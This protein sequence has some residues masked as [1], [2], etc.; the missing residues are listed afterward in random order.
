MPVPLTH[1]G[2]YITE[3]PSGTRTITGVATSITAFVGTALRGP[4]DEPVTIFTY[5]DFVRVFG[6]LSTSSGLGY[7]VRDM[8]LNGGGE[9]VIVRIAPG[10]GAARVVAAGL[11]PADGL[12]LVA[13]GPGSWGNALSIIVEHPDGVDEVAA[14]QGVE[15]DDL[16]Q[17]TVTDGLTE[18]IYLNV[19]VVEGPRRIDRVLATSALIAVEGALP[20]TRPAASP[21][22]APY[23]VSA[24]GQGTDGTLPLDIT[25]EHY[26]GDGLVADKGGVYA[27]L[28]ADLFNLLCLPPPAPEL[29][30][31]AD[32]W[33]KALKFC[34][35]QRAFLIVDVPGALG[36]DGAKTWATG[37][38]LT[39]VNARNG[40]AYYPRLRA[41]DPL[42][43]GTIQDYVPCGAVAGLMART[44]AT[45]G[46]WKAPAGIDSAV[47]AV[48]GLSR[49]L[50]D[51]ENGVLNPVAVNCLRTFRGFGT[52]IWGA[53][54][55]RG[56]D[57]L[58]DEYKYVPVR[59]LALS[60]EETLY[61]NTQWVVFE[62]ND[63]PLW[64]QIRTSIGAFMQDLFRQG[65]FQGTTPRDAFFVRCDAET[66]TQYDI[67]RGIVNILV[68]FAPLKP[69][70]FVVISLQQKTATP[71]A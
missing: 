69:A 3:I 17:L 68:G 32:T 5:T 50:T 10:A 38:G 42:R 45:R 60:L 2:V 22:G 65:A 6:G 41:P 31:P 23:T 13:S 61:R 7:A 9:A 29:D 44:D 34:A 20:G 46:V 40:A 59:R 48:N 11:T 67:D 35:E 21:V 18:E 66:T 56:A 64:A 58:G 55:L 1:P 43:G 26:A 47:T 57:L 4:V 39:G 49:T 15:P 71:A 53:R 14:A 12:T 24:A 36:V 51:G 63:E 37:V 30:L 28:K 52:V 8:Y 62:P 27:L 25:S 70:E 19:T 54:T 33:P 16:F